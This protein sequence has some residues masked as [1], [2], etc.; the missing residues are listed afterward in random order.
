M[1]DPLI[2]AQLNTLY[3]DLITLTLTRINSVLRLLF[4]NSIKDIGQTSV[5]AGRAWVMLVS[6]Y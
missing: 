2:H 6:L 4:N 3:H 1:A 5:K